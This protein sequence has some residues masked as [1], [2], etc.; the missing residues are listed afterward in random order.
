MSD[1]VR[2]HVY[3]LLTNCTSY[4]C[5]SSIANYHYRQTKPNIRLPTTN[6]RHHSLVLVVLVAS[7]WC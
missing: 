3:R 1:P 4:F 5:L 6:A 7:S 2:G